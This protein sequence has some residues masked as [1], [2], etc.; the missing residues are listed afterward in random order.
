MVAMNFNKFRKANFCKFQYHI[1]RGFS[2]LEVMVAVT[3]FTLVMI[4]AGGS[5]ISVQRAWLIQRGTIDRIQNARW[6]M[7]LMSNEIRHST[8]SGGWG[9]IT[10]QNNGR[11]LRVG[12]DTDGDNV[13]DTRVV[14]W[15]G[16]TS[17]DA[18]VDGYSDYLYRGVGNNSSQAYPTRQQLANFVVDNPINP[19]TGNPYPIFEESGGIVTIR[20]T[21]ER[22]SRS[23]TLRTQVRPRN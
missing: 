23:Y 20:L 1:R 17:S 5:F 13:P 12:I 15:R 10:V 21:V 11:T 18:I 6:A 16:S 2:L 22:D 4:A 9:D 14:Y 19:L 7:E 8:A 3:V